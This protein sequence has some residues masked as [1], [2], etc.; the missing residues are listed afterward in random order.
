MTATDP[1]FALLV[2]AGA[3]SDVKPEPTGLGLIGRAA[4]GSCVGVLLSVLLSVL[5]FEGSYAGVRDDGSAEQAIAASRPLLEALA[6][7]LAWLSLLQALCFTPAVLGLLL[8]LRVSSRTRSWARGRV[9]VPVVLGLLA[10]FAFGAGVA[11]RHPGLFLSLLAGSRWLTWSARFGHVLVVV[12]FGAAV[13]GYVFTALR[14]RQSWRV[15]S[16]CGGTLLLPLAAWLTVLFLPGPVQVFGSKEALAAAPLQQRVD[17]PNVLVLAVDSLR[18]DMLDAQHT[19]NLQRLLEESIYFPNALVTQPRTGP[20]WAATLTSLPPLLNGV[21]TMF[22]NAQL[23]HLQT[24]ALP[25]H[26]GT[27][28]YRTGVFSEYAG[29]FFSRVDFGFDVRAVPS[30]ELDDITGQMLL[31]RV[32]SLL[33]VG[34]AFYTQGRAGRAALGPRLGNLMRGMANFAWPDVLADDMLVQARLERRQAGPQAPP[35]FWLAFY[36]QPHFPYTSSSD[37]YPD[38]AVDGATPELRFGRDAANEVPISSDED[39]RQLVG[40]YRAALAQTDAAIGKLLARLRAQRLLDDTIIVLLADHGEGLY[41]CGTCVGHGDNLK[42]MVTLRVPLAFH[43]PRSRYPEAIASRYEGYVSQLDVYPTL[44]ELLA[45]PLAPHHAGVPLVNGTG[46]LRSL[47]ERVHFAETGEWLWPT[48]AVPADR[49]AYPV[50]T[51]LAKLERGRI[52]IDPKHNPE[53]RAGKQRAVIRPPYKL[54]YEPGASQVQYHLYQFEQDPWELEDLASSQPQI[55]EELKR[56]LF[57]SML[58]HPQVLS[59]ADYFLTRPEPPPPENW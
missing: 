56:D 24:L 16:A 31:M 58:R 34:S 7:Q 2:T 50:I 9:L 28:G 47:P 55:V 21:E 57:R 29:E 1:D 11:H 5:F 13:L 26:L 10:V 38:Y 48:P 23:S 40:L 32:P 44:L 4:L 35:F 8:L 46:L 53:I 36:S 30:V 12:V 19:P 49:I 43:L 14:P 45:Q 39:K 27:L 59:L 25:A 15:V 18:P 3:A 41:E 17:L 22:P 20:S 51:E 42:S 54:S 52:V 6:R 37:F 33:A